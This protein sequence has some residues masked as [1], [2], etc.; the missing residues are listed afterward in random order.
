M[1][2][3]ISLFISVLVSLFIVFFTNI[4]NTLAFRELAVAHGVSITFPLVFLAI[5]TISF[6]VILLLYALSRLVID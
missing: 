1:K 3:L 2:A 4:T 5:L 6:A